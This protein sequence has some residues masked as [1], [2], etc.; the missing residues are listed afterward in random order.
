MVKLSILFRQPTDETG[1]EQ[2]Y[3]HTLALMEKMPGIRRRQAC[4]VFGSPAGKSPF[5]RV[6]ELYFDDNTALDL[7][8]RSPEGRAAGADLMQFARTAE[9][10][11]SDVYED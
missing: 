7:A 9:V 2:G 11:F 4:M 10:I 3:N 5:Y 1:F 8:L 6:L